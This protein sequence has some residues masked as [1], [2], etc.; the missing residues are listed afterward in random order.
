MFSV[1]ATY[2]GAEQSMKDHMDEITHRVKV[3]EHQ[4]TFYWFDFDDDE[5][6]AQGQTYQDVIDVVKSRFPTHMFVLSTDKE[7]WLIAEKTD[8]KMSE[9]KV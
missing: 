1:H 9:I 4:G 3:E 2:K 8:W 7:M 5:F 6:L